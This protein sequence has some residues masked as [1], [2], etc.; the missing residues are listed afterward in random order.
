MTP[1]DSPIVHQPAFSQQAE[2]S[3]QQIDSGN[4]SPLVLQGWPRRQNQP[5]TINSL[6]SNPS[7]PTAAQP[8]NAIDRQ[9]RP[10]STLHQTQGSLIGSS[11]Q[12]DFQDHDPTVSPI[13]RQPSQSSPF[14]QHPAHGSKG[15]FT[16]QEW[17]RVQV[18]TPLQHGINP[19]NPSPDISVGSPGAP[20]ALGAPGI[21]NPSNR[22]FRTTP[23]RQQSKDQNVTNNNQRAHGVSG[24]EIQP[25][26]RA[27]PQILSAAIPTQPDPNSPTRPSRF[28]FNLQPM[29]QE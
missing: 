23:N 2:P 20:G 10:I 16:T 14:I 5:P 29:P 3:H 22:Q 8:M 13:T 4:N 24:S 26:I 12:P 18:D 15:Q 6:T 9:F 11:T 17:P 7:S 25:L 1:T 19:N 21:A 28:T 27:L